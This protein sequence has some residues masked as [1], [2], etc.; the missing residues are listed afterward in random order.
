MQFNK[1][2]QELIKRYLYISKNS[3]FLLKNLDN[4]DLDLYTSLEYVLL[5]DKNLENNQHYCYI[6]H[7]KSTL[8]Y[9]T[10][11]IEYNNENMITLLSKIYNYISNQKKDDNNRIVKLQVIKEYLNLCD[12]VDKNIKKTKMIR[13]KEDV[14]VINNGFINNFSYGPEYFYNDCDHFNNEEKQFIKTNY[15]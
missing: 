5:S 8:N 15:R 9:K 7:I 12:Y 11:C 10:N 14:G 2:K 3:D 4:K 13:N 6:E 1:F